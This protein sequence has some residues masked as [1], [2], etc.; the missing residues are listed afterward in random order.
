HEHIGCAV[1][2]VFVIDAGRAPRLHRDR[3][4]SFG[5]ELLGRLVQTNHRAIG[6]A[7]PRIDREHILHRRYER[8]AGLG[9]DDP[10]FA[11]VGLKSVF[12]STRWIVESLAASTMP[13]STTLLSN[14]RKLQRAYPGRLGAGKG[15]QP[16]FLL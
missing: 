6:I 3:R 2:R 12:L 1:A 8:A 16:G 7:G 5:D 14:S 9:R 4:A 10:I 15:D 13:N 11:A